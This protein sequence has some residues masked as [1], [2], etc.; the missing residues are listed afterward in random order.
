MVSLYQ[1]NSGLQDTG[2]LLHP[3]RLQV[4][5]KA[6]AE[7]HL[8]L[9]LPSRLI[10]STIPPLALLPR[11]LARHLRDNLSVNAQATP[12]P[13]GTQMIS[14]L[15]RSAKVPIGTPFSILRCSVCWTLSSFTTWSTTVLFV[16]C[17][18]AEMASTLPLVVTDRLRS[19]TLLPARM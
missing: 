19:S 11:S 7:L 10:S 16:V 5:A 17:D 13:I 4:P 2:R 15:L 6:V 18:S 3:L 9:P 8:D 12:L 1:T 14:L